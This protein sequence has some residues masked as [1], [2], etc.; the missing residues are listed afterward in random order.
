M[1]I[2]A[3]NIFLIDFSSDHSDD[4]KKRKL[5]ESSD[6]YENDSRDRK[7]KKKKVSSK[8]SLINLSI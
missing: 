6:R 2:F 8:F 5:D 1:H 4:P 7:S 3:Y